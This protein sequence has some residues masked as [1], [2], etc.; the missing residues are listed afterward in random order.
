LE[1]SGGEVLIM[2]TA[3][4]FEHPE[5]AVENAQRWFASLGG[6]ASGLNVLGRGDAMEAGNAAVV[7]SSRFVYLSGGSPLHLRSVVKATPLWDALVAAWEGGATVAASSAGAMVLTDPMIDPR[8]GAFTLGLGLV[9]QLAVIPHFQ[10]WSH[11]KAERTV[12]LAGPGLVVAGIDEAT[13]LVRRPDGSW[14]AQGKGNVVLWSG[15]AKV[16]VSELAGL[17]G[18]SGGG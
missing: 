3:A 13:A 7:A 17:L 4:A 11:D 6:K 5:R 15:G 9:R 14:Q 10:S 12:A 2:P 8:G 18:S 1:G 16:A